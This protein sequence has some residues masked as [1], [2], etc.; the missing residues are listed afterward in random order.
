MKA[1]TLTHSFGFCY[2]SARWGYSSAG[3]A[4]RSHRRGRGFESP[5]LHHYGVALHL[6]DEGVR[7]YRLEIRLSVIPKPG[8]G[9]RTV[10]ESKVSPAFKGEGEVDYICGCC[11]AILAENVRQGQIKNIVIHCP[12]CGQYNEFP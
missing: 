10:I 5:Y 4:L 3:R 12:K 6:G 7:K 1:I 8:E 11:G 2:N 9:V